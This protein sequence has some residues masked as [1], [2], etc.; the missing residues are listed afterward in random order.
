MEK[1]LIDIAI[2]NLNNQP[3][4]LA[5]WLDN[6]ELDGTLRIVINKKEYCYNIEVKKELRQYQ[7]TRINEIKERIDNLIII[8]EQIYPKVKE[9]LKELKIPYL[10][11]NGN[12]FFQTE[13]C[14]CL[15]DTKKK[16]PI[17]KEKANRAF[18]KTGLKVVFHLLNNPELINKKQREIANAAGVALGNIP[19]VIN[20]LKET[21]YLLNIRKGVYV[22]EKKEELINRW[23]NNYATELRPKLIIGNYTIKGNWQDINLNENK[24]VWGGEPAA[25][26]LTQYLRP[27]KFLI[28]TKERKLNLIK[29]YKLIP[30]ENGEL[31][32]LEMFWDNTKNA[33]FAPP[34]LVYAELI[35]T[36]G[37]R[38]VETAELIYNDYIK[39][40]L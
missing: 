38:N 30:K 12:F 24:T 34:L 8:A 7:I 6:R 14:F 35:L 26:I 16:A 40:E 37:K 4:I 27:E 29:E 36:G 23:I 21:G 33:M 25:D 32:V 9:Q 1:E 18:T 10:E 20:G 39:P 17:R 15:I 11:T 22:W 13:E 31:E 5:E 2:E 3:N 28:Y 19:Q